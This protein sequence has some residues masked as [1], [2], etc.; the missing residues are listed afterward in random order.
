MR[1]SPSG[2]CHTAY[3]PAMLASST[4]AVQMLLVAFSRR[5]CC[6]R[7][8]RARR[9]AGRPAVS[10]LTP[11]RRPG[12]A[13]ACASRVARKRGVRAAEAHRH[14][15]A[16][17]RA[18]A[19]SAPSAPGGVEQHAGEQIGGDDGE[20][21]GVVDRGRS[22]RSSRRQRA[23]RAGGTEQRAE[24]PPPGRASVRGRRRRVR[25]RSARPGCAAR[26]SSAGGCRRGRRSVSVVALRQ[27]AGHRHG[28]GRGGGL[29]EHRGVGQVEPGEVG[30]HRLEVEDRLQAALADLRLVRRVGRVPGRVLEHVAQ[31]DRRGDRAVVPHADQA[32]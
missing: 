19:M 29:V 12:S 23:G 9:S 26:R 15:E 4:C 16:L 13:R 6:S 24:A 32:R 21:A 27:P 22:P 7:V 3:M 17:G 25:C 2:P 20:P 18:D 5:M 8:C 14:A 30:H 11:T 28:L 10:V 1:V 31:D